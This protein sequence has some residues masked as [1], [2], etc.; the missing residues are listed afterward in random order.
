MQHRLL[1]RLA[2][3]CTAAL[4]LTTALLFSAGPQSATAQ[5]VR[6]FDEPLAPY[7][8]WVD[9]PYY[10]RVWRPR[11]TPADWRPYVYGRWVYTSEYG[12]VWVSEEPW[13]WVVYHY[14]HWVWNSHY[15]WV[16][17]AGDVWGPS[18][19]EWCYGGGYVGWTP[20]PPDPYWQ[21]GYYHGVYDCSSPRYHSS[22]VFV[23]EAYFASPRVSAHL[24]APAQNALVARGTVNVTNYARRDGLIANRSIDIARLQAAT[25]HPIRPI[26]V[27]QANGPVPV[28]ASRGA[29]QELRIYRPAVAALGAP[30]L[31]I[32]KPPK[33]DLEPDFKS[34]PLAP[35]PLDTGALR[36]PAL[37]R[38]IDSPSLPSLGNGGIPG[39]G[40]VDL[41]GGAL[42]GVRG[43]L[44]R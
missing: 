42:G 27:V 22:A 15:G 31:D 5:P 44:G 32:G 10:G 23:S 8:Y 17:V 13:G 35:A 6:Y 3:R 4:L 29:L 25:G 11:E 30:R 37:G 7:G 9:D 16:W 43:R 40:G 38:P 12:W 41:G 28:G 34:V 19:V 21:G 1:V 36:A 18:W 39:V 24:V 20:M 14:G 26:R 33:L 2:R